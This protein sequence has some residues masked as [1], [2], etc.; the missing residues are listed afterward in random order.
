MRTIT[1]PKPKVQRQKTFK[2]AVAVMCVCVGI[3][4][5]FFAAEGC[6]SNDESA[7]PSSRILMFDNVTLAT[8]DLP[9]IY[10]DSEIPTGSFNEEGYYLSPRF[11]LFTGDSIEVRITSDGPVKLSAN[12]S[13]SEGS[14]QTGL[15]SISEENEPSANISL[16]YFDVIQETSS[17]TLWQLTYIFPSSKLPSSYY[18]IPSG[19]YQLSIYNGTGKAAHCEFT[20]TLE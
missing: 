20:I 14:I 1:A 11:Y 7:A 18:Q 5:T 15:N 10:A 12:Y 3:L 8:G 17:G 16:E 19:F 13:D 9:E 2:A 4:A 6:K